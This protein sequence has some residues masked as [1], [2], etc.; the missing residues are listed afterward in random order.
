M[1]S[2]RTRPIRISAVF[3]LLLACCL[4]LPMALTTQSALAEDWTRTNLPGFGNNNNEYVSSM[5]TNG[6]YLFA[7]TYNSTGGAGSGAEV[8]RYDGASWVRVGRNGLG[9]P[10][11]SEVVSL[12][13]FHGYVY[14]GTYNWNDGCEVRRYDGG[15]SWSL[16]ISSGFGDAYNRGASSMLYNDAADSFCVGTDNGVTGSE[17]WA[18]A[19]AI[20]AGQS[21]WNQ[22][23]LDGY[24]TDNQNFNTSALCMFNGRGFLR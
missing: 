11:N 19:A 22:Y 10:D 18:T 16:V 21:D 9:N 24:N 4:V 5:V 23:N 2:N 6:P 3:A 8:W 13:V 12:C 1:L 7:G 17:L 20:P 15:T 14:A